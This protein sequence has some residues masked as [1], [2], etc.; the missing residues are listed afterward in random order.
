MPESLPAELVTLRERAE[1]FAV[2]VLLP[3][4]QARN[5]GS[6]S[7]PVVR[8]AVTR[9]A[10]EAG[11]FAMTQPKSHGGS[12][13]GPLALTVVRD[14]LTGYNSGLDHIV[15]GPGPGVLAATAQRG[16]ARGLCVYRTR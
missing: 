8:D 4:Q 1:R 6:A 13:A 11:F 2:E 14:T 9:A 3:H 10:R 15:F 7:L 5:T 16:K 12:E